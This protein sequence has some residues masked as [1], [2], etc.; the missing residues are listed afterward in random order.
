[1]PPGGDVKDAAADAS[2]TVHDCA[3]IGVARASIA[4]VTGSVA[5]TFPHGKTM[6]E[7]ETAFCCDAAVLPK[8]LAL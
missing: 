2:M 3:C 6:H 5:T 7:G 8:V 4:S 1:M